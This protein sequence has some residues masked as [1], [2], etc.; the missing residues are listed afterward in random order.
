MLMGMIG[1]GAGAGGGGSW[2]P[3]SVTTAFWFDASDNT[4]VFK[5][6]GVTQAVAGT[7]TVQQWNDKSGNGRNFS[8]ATAGNRGKY[9]AS[10]LNSLNGIDFHP[11]GVDA[12]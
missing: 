4:T 6:A 5:D 1:P 12:S 9:T 2:T 3:A 10:V 11:T 8:Q 7:D